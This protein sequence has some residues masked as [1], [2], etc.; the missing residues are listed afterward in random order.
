M[1]INISAYDSHSMNQNLEKCK[2]NER[3]IKKNDDKAIFICQ[4]LRQLPIATFQKKG[5][6]YL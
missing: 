5:K 4:S 6:F 2:L 3:D 1:V